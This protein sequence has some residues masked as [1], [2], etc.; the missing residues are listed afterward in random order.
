MLLP[1]TYVLVESHP[2]SVFSVGMQ[3]LTLEYPLFQ[4]PSGEK[5]VEGAS[6]DPME[7]GKKRS[8]DKEVS[9]GATHQLSKP[10]ITDI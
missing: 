3:Q 4:V 6:Q 10:I 5:V 2:P 9:L 7:V 8:V 1:N